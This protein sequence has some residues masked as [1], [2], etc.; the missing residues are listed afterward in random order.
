ME[1][2]KHREPTLV[3]NAAFYTSQNASSSRVVAGRESNNVKSL[4]DTLYA[5]YKFLRP[6]SLIGV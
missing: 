6:Y 2:I 5:T 4:G 3:A 1:S